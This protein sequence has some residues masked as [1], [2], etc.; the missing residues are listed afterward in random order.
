MTASRAIVV[1]ARR[2]AAFDAGSTVDFAEPTTKRAPYSNRHLALH[3]HPVA[4]SGRRTT[5][6]Q[7]PV[8]VERVRL[9]PEHEA[10]V[11]EGLAQ[12]ERGEGMVLTTEELERIAATGEWPAWRD[13]RD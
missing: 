8:R 12:L 4:M 10:Q 3:C 6:S 11:R 2:S 9:T 1:L 13:D 7:P 5:E